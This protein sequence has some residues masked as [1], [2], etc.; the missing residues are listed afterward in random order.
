MESSTHL[1]TSQRME[2]L[3]S[4]PAYT[5]TSEKRSGLDVIY[6]NSRNELMVS[7]YRTLFLIDK[8][9]QVKKE[10]AG[11]IHG[12]NDF[13]GCVYAEVLG[14]PNLF[15]VDKETLSASQTPISSLY[16]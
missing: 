1:D 10:V 3:F 6:E 2:H 14:N 8:E 7:H 5:R 11:I 15:V 4:R 9:G 16:T 13:S 12:S